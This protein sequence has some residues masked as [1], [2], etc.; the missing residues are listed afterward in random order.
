MFLFS[1]VSAL[2]S[3]CYLWDKPRENTNEIIGMGFESQ[4]SSKSRDL[5]LRPLEG[6]ELS[7]M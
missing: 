1:S 6:F 3:F 7:H 2:Y 4:S 5:P